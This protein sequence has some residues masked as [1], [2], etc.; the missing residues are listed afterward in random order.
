[1][2]LKTT[3]SNNDVQMSVWSEICCAIWTQFPHTLLILN[4]VF[5][6][7]DARS[8]SVTSMLQGNC[9]L[10][11][12]GKHQKLPATQ[13]LLLAEGWS[14]S[15]ESLQELFLFGIHFPEK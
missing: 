2:H 5:W 11:R 7:R 1:M 10:E 9:Y 12:E 8:G 15:S 4:N 3:G 6:K 13:K 14:V